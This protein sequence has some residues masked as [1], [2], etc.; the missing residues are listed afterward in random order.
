MEQ[1]QEFLPNGSKESD[2]KAFFLEELKKEGIDASFLTKNIK[3]IIENENQFSEEMSQAG[4]SQ[5]V[6][7]EQISKLMNAT[8]LTN[9][10]MEIP[11]NIARVKATELLSELMGLRKGDAQKVNSIRLL[12]DTM[13]LRNGSGVNINFNFT[14][15]LYGR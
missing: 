11:D 5:K 15:M 8:T 2:E 3:K 12:M 7:F 14:D 6:L 10:G 4:L 1:R 13:G 9:D